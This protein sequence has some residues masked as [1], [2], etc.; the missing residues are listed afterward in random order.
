MDVFL[1]FAK[2]FISGGQSNEWKCT[3]VHV[4]EM[5][6][7][8][9]Q[10]YESMDWEEIPAV[11]YAKKSKVSETIDTKT[12]FTFHHS[13]P[14]ATPN[15]ATLTPP[16]PKKLSSMAHSEIIRRKIPNLKKYLGL[17]EMD[18]LLVFFN[19]KS[20]FVAN[21]YIEDTF[22]KEIVCCNVQYLDMWCS[23]DFNNSAPETYRV[24]TKQIS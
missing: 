17:N 20:I 8:S 2:I 1:T 5:E 4:K 11:R 7:E 18:L 24:N 14:A 12:I 15:E 23:L 21:K 19:E 16:A 6:R 9:S 13:M 10:D 3:E 22:Y